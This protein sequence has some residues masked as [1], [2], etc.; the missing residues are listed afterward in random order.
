MKNR[1]TLHGFKRKFNVCIILFFMLLIDGSLSLCDPRTTMMMC[2]H[3]WYQSKAN[4]QAFTFKIENNSTKPENTIV[5][6]EP[7][8]VID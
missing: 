2:C 5:S 8:S 7:E 3:V 4:R 1:D 6:L